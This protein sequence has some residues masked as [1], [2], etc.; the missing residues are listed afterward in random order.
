MTNKMIFLLL[1]MAFKFITN[2]P[3]QKQTQKVFYTYFN[4]LWFTLIELIIVIAIIAILTVSAMMLLTKWLSKSRD[5]RRMADL[6]NIK[7]ALQVS[8]VEKEKYP[9]PDEYTTFLAS[10]IN[11]WYQWVIK[12]G[13][14]EKIDSLKRV[15]K[16]PDGSYYTYRVNTKQNK[17]EI[18]AYLENWIDMW[19]LVDNKIFA[20]SYYNKNIFIKWHNMWLITDNN[21]KPINLVLNWT[22]EIDLVN[23]SDVLTAYFKEW[24]ITWTW[25]DLITVVLA[26]VSSEE[27]KNLILSY[28]KSLVW[29]W[30]FDKGTGNVVYDSSSYNN[31]GIIYWWAN[32]T[33]W[34]IWKALFFDWNDDYVEINDSDS[35]DV[36]KISISAY[37]NTYGTGINSSY[38]P[39]IVSKWWTT[40]SEQ[41]G[42]WIGYK[43]DGE[44]ISKI[45]A[46]LDVSTLNNNTWIWTDN[47]WDLKNKWHH[48]VI[49]YDWDKLLYY[50][51]WEKV[52]EDNESFKGDIVSS[53]KH[54]IIWNVWRDWDYD[55]AFYGLIDDV[56][57]Y[58]RVL[59]NEEIRNMY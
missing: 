40:N 8:F 59:S 55:R 48:I 1:L 51:D 37:I 41:Y 27:E 26:N 44:Y 46:R 12:T 50:L 57:I 19:Y 14:I 31:S 7:N 6:E 56:R 29:W 23:T 54:L 11:I 16:D 39:R 10:G 34:K 2:L 9:L 18:V 42:L 5:S 28:D 4:K 53:T 58:N 35:L 15:L 30:K 36:Q 3:M 33:S 47:Y 49:T 38:W 43:Q 21:K 22:W 25:K 52:A 17:F 20:D 24:I 13:V 45:N 32:W